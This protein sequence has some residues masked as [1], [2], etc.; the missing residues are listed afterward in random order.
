SLLS[1]GS[2]SSPVSNSS[3][4]AETVAAGSALE[5][6]SESNS[7]HPANGTP[8]AK[9][10]AAHRSSLPERDATARGFSDITTLYRHNDPVGSHRS[11]HFLIGVLV[12]SFLMGG[13][14]QRFAGQ[15][16]P[17]RPL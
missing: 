17:G 3:T 16:Q 6:V 2:C 14:R 1:V 13:V 7:A 8:T 10:M 9:A 15:R 5:L 11:G 12:W 4:S